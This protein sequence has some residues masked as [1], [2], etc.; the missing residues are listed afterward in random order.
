MTKQDRNQ[1]N[2]FLSTFR[3]V[4][5]DKAE[6]IREE[7]LLLVDEMV[8]EGMNDGREPPSGYFDLLAG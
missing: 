2:F 4:G 6:E 8:A 5:S 3:L 7:I 1:S